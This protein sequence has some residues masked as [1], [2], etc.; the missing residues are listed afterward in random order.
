MYTH[1][2]DTQDSLKIRIKLLTID[3]IKTSNHFGI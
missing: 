1:F 2:V 3:L